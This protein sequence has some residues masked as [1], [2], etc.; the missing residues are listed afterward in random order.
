MATTVQISNPPMLS[1]DIKYDEGG[2]PFVRDSSGAW[3]PHPDFS[4]VCPL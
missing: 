3:I 1:G 4:K 2:N